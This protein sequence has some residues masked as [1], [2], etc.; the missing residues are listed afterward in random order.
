M[1]GTKR[2]LAALGMALSAAA[3]PALAQGGNAASPPSAT[4]A[5]VMQ[6]AVCV[7]EH[8]PNAGAALLATQPFSG[9]EGHR[10]SDIIHDARRCLRSH[11]SIATTGLAMRAAVAE[12][13][14]EA[15]FATPAT[16][17]DPALAAAPLPRPADG[18]Q[19]ATVLAMMYGLV[20]CATPS[21]PD[22]VR[23]VLATEPGTPEETAA[24]TALHPAFI[25][26][27][28]AGTHLS[29]DPHI[30]RGMFAESLY[31]WSVVQRDGPASPWAASAA[32]AQ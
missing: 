11:D 32:A 13:S 9:D 8:N 7:V 4:P 10:A 12:A 23:A 20:D 22:L 18:S 19:P 25:A 3:A 31:R 15:Q 17:R 29:Y 30:I 1:K 5:E 28:P 16:P 24:L 21:H 6:A 2:L 26:C 27:V 14:Y